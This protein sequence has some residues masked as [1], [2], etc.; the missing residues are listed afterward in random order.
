MPDTPATFGQSVLNAQLDYIQYDLTKEAM[1]ATFVALCKNYSRAD[2]YGTVVPGK[3]VAK[4]AISEDDAFWGGRDPITSGGTD[5]ADAPSQRQTCTAVE[6]A[7][8]LL[9]TD[10]T[11][12]ELSVILYSGTEILAVTNENS[13]S[14]AVAQD[15]VITTFEFYIQATQPGTAV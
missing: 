12:D 1:G 9:T 13:A 5:D 3:I 7:P 2:A 14:R 6:L 11:N 8:A 10:G 4:L 15:D